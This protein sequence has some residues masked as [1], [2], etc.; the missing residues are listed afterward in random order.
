MY[1]QS[2]E[3]VLEYLIVY[4]TYHTCPVYG[5]LARMVPDKMVC[6]Q[7]LTLCILSFV[8]GGWALFD[9]LSR[10]WWARP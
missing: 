5:T 4:H 9:P 10:P 2:S 8:G 7:G 1:V 3:N 6:R